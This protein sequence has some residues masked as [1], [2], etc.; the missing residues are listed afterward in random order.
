MDAT[1]LD[2]SG[3]ERALEEAIKRN[4]FLRDQFA[5]EPRK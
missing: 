3:L 2:L 4:A 1:G 5:S